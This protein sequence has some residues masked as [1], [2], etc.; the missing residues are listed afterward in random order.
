MLTCR[1]G[2]A[3]KIELGLCLGFRVGHDQLWSIL[4]DQM[5]V[6][7]SVP[8]KCLISRPFLLDLS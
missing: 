4:C 2:V 5:V 8:I 1:V 3:F 6:L 7:F